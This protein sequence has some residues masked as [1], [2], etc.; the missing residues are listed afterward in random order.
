M[1][2]DFGLSLP[3][4]PP[5]HRITEWM[6]DIDATL[7]HL[8]P[9]F[10][11]LWMTDHFFWGA[12]PTYEAW[13]VLAYI[14]GR[15][16][17]ITFGP[18]VL[19]QSY[20]NPAMTAKMAATLQLLSGGRLIMGIGAGWKEDEYHAYGYPYPSP[21]TRVAQLEDTIK[22]FKLLWTEGGR[23]T[24]RGPQYQI[25][26]AY[27]EPKPEPVPPL[28]VGGGGRKTTLLAVKY[29]DMWNMPDAPFAEYRKRLDMIEEHCDAEGRDPATLR[30]S[31]FGR[32][33]VGKTEADAIA[34]SDGKWH[35]DNAFCGT[36]EQVLEQMGPFI[37]AGVDMFMVDVLGTDVPDV[38][39][40]ITEEVVPKAQAL[41][42]N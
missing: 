20:R 36:P 31:W 9:H 30:R 6:D 8:G 25:V 16:P 28:L 35:A 22:I 37:E 24:Y 38:I 29:A 1:S 23:V 10:T 4:G 2:V 33:A 5:P 34:L 11:S 7:Q 39:G 12:D 19:G 42:S 21:G 17:D 18:M 40:M 13:T 41:A 26:D 32:L 15:W 3:A 14:A 27:C